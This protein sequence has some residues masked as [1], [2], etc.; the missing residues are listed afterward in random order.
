[1]ITNRIVGQKSASRVKNSQ[2]SCP[3][4]KSIWQI[5]KQKV[6]VGGKWCNFIFKKI[7]GEKRLG[8][9]GPW[10]ARSVERSVIFHR[11]IY[12]VPVEV[13]QRKR[14]GLQR[15]QKCLIP[16]QLKANNDLSRIARRLKS[17]LWCGDALC[18]KYMAVMSKRHPVQTGG[19]SATATL[20]QEYWY[21]CTRNTGTAV[22]GEGESYAFTALATKI[23]CP[24]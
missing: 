16:V 7:Q 5:M 18:M 22:P 24:L 4:C 21:S 10:G 13:S 12:S 14:R 3:L 19:K 11:S 9:C 15:F 6:I 20:Y 1:M 2:E 23:L 17:G 8:F